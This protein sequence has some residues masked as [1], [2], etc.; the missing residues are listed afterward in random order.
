MCIRDRGKEYYDAIREGA[1][2]KTGLISS[3]I[4]E[5]TFREIIEADKMC[6]RDRVS[7]CTRRCSVS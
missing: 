5:D 3:G 2:I 4:F 7:S 1:E 6:I